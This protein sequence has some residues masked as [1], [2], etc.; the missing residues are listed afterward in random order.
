MV[1]DQLLVGAGRQRST[2]GAPLTSKC[3]MHQAQPLLCTNK[4]QGNL[5]LHAGDRGSPTALGR[6]GAAA[7]AQFTVPTASAGAGPICPA[8]MCKGQHC[9][10]DIPNDT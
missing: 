3:P 9:N 8:D 7:L 5:Q 10:H 6:S 2:A 1:D 4:T